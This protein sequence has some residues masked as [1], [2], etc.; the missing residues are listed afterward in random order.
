[1][2][3]KDEK[4]HKQLQS[5]T[6]M[7]EQLNNQIQASDIKTLAEEKKEKDELVN[8]GLDGEGDISD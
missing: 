3:C 5:K 1:M 8:M 2:A 7:N 6:E 4:L